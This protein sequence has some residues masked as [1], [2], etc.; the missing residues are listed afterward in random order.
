M[1]KL[2]A[3]LEKDPKYSI[4]V[5]D[6]VQSY[7]TLEEK[8]KIQNHRYDK[9]LQEL[10]DLKQRHE[11]GLKRNADEEEYPNGLTDKSNV[12]LSILEGDNLGDSNSNSFVVIT[13]QGKQKQTRIKP[14]TNYPEWNEEFKF[15]VVHPQGMIKIEVFDSTFF[16]NTS[17]GLVQFNLDS[18]KDQ[19]KICRWIDLLNENDKRQKGKL[20]IKLQ[21]I[22]SLKKYYTEEIDLINKKIKFLKDAVDQSSNYVNNMN[23]DFSVVYSGDIDPLYDRTTFDIADKIINQ[24]ETEKIKKKKTSSSIRFEKEEE[25]GLFDFIGNFFK[26]LGG[27]CGFCNEH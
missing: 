21:Y 5:H 6:F 9:F 12:Y 23:D 15:N 16:G 22:I 2:Y 18:L 14:K 20:F 19:K 7:I 17:L 8:I 4:T 3:I 25:E 1:Q 24:H 26:G 10:L 11:E 13:F 27:V